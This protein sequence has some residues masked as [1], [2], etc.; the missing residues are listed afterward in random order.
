MLCS[1]I[2]HL[3][4]ME[5]ATDFIRNASYRYFSMVCSFKCV[6]PFVHLQAGILNDRLVSYKV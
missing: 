5:N 4:V 2:T 1:V 3:G 6:R